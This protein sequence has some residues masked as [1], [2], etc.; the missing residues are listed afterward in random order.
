[1]FCKFDVR[2]CWVFSS[3]EHVCPRGVSG[4]PCKFSSVSVKLL[5][6]L[7]RDPLLVRGLCSEDR[8]AFELLSRC[9]CESSKPAMEYVIDIFV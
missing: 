3:M 4:Y 5:L 6:S 2:K 7:G 1:M 8:T 9:L